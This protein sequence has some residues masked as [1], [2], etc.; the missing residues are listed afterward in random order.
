MPRTLPPRGR[1]IALS[2]SVLLALGVPACGE[3]NDNS[4]EPGSTSTQAAVGGSEREQARAA[5]ENLYSAI[6]DGDAQQVCDSLTT[7][8]QKQVAAGGLGGKSDTCADAFQKFLDAAE[9]Q[10]G[11]NLTLKAKVE[12]VRI[13]GD[14]AVATVS[15]GGPG[16]TGPVPLVRQGGEWKVDQAGAQ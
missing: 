12:K 2:A 1:V 13:D 10:G 7:A 9:R 11:L 4:D 8:G 14:K 5:V 15:F 6:R 16:R 3:D